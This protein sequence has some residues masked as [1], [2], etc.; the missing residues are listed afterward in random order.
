LKRGNQGCCFRLNANFPHR[1]HSQVPPGSAEDRGGK[2]A[3]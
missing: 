1:T 2:E 3:R